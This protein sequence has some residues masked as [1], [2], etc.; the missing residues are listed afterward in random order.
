MKTLKNIL[1][2]F[3]A[4]L[5]IASCEDKREFDMPPINEPKFDGEANTTIQQLKE[6]FAGNQLT[7]ITEPIIISGLV[8]ANDISGNIYKQIQLQDETGG[9]A[10]SI[11]Q[12]S[13][14]NDYRVGQE[15]FLECKG[16]YFGLYGGNPQLGYLYSRDNDGRYAIGQMTWELFRKNAHLNGFPQP[17]LIEPEVF[18]IG[19]LNNSHVGKLVT[20][21]DV[22]FENGGI[23]PFASP[24]TGGG[25][26]TESKR[27]ISVSNVADTL[28]IR[29]SSASNFASFIMPAGMGTV[30]GVLSIFNGTRQLTFR[31]SL[32]C[33][34]TR[35]TAWQGNGTMAT[36]W[37][38]EFALNNQ[39]RELSGWIEGYIV[40]TVAPGI[41]TE[42]PITG[43]DDIIFEAPFFNNTVVIAASPDVKDWTKCV[44]VKLPENSEM[45]DIVNLMDIP[46][47]WGQILK[48]RGTLQNTFGAAGLEVR[49]GSAEDFLLGE[50]GSKT[51][52]FTVIEA[53]GRQGMS[54]EPFWVRGYIIGCINT[55][56]GTVT[57]TF[58]NTNLA[59]GSDVYGTRHVSV[60]LPFGAV[61]NAL[62]LVS[63][64]G[65]LRREV[66]VLGTLS[67]YGATD[68]IRDVDDFVF[69]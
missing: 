62:N 18:T 23:E 47:N 50:K 61:R 46:S 69:R 8:V 65:N 15:V 63:N 29:N 43:N 66:I 20:V 58:V 36:P 2:L 22:Y 54:S 3:A 40:G 49:T 6:K 35:F 19:Q 64:P 60:Q 28:I 56:N 10:I 1:L 48:V 30:T 67:R 26:Q 53:I 68:G 41:N 9:I 32:D 7:E 57:Q 31:D 5:L 24:R 25:T 55:T 17:N 44:V 11:D 51:N 38:I 39:A 14:Y 33:S 42:H 52:P 12:N 13:I 59:L 37:S 4:I 45:F 16:L 21:K 27:L 34:P